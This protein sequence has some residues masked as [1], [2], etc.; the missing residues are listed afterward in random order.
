[1]S[2]RAH[3]SLSKRS[4]IQWS[5]KQG[6]HYNKYPRSASSAHWPK[7][8]VTVDTIE[9]ARFHRY[10]PGYIRVCTATIAR[11]RSHNFSLA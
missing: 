1:M 4:I 5:S 9:C 8:C 3:H 11:R 10:A 2:S 6:N 7:R